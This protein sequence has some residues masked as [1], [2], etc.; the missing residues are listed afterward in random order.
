M[1]RIIG[2]YWLTHGIISMVAAI[3]PPPGYSTEDYVVAFLP[4]MLIGVVL[5]FKADAIAETLYGFDG[6]ADDDNVG[7]ANSDSDQGDN[8]S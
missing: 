7:S 5:T 3:R 2:L 1:A 8:R 4:E 6:L